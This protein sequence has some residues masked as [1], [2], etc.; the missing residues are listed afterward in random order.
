MYSDVASEYKPVTN[1]VILYYHTAVVL[2]KRPQFTANTEILLVNLNLRSINQTK[3][4]ILSV[5]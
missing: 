2:V 4:S 1:R 3:L 5:V